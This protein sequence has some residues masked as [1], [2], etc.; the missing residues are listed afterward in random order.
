MNRAINIIPH[1]YKTYNSFFN[2]KPGT[3]IHVTSGNHGK[4]LESLLIQIY[5]TLSES[6]NNISSL[7]KK[8]INELN[9]EIKFKYQNLYN[10]R[11]L[12]FLFINFM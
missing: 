7:L 5:C 12:I 8:F 11:T 2:W 10:W 4:V 3:K 9:E 1:H 6:F